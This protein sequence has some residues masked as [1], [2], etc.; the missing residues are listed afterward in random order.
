MLIKKLGAV[1]LTAIMTFIFISQD[2]K[3]SGQKTDSGAFS[4]NTREENYS[5]D[6]ND[7]NGRPRTVDPTRGIVVDDDSRCPGTDYQTIQAAVNAASP[8]DL[9]Q[10][11]PGVYQEQVAIS[12]RL[13]IVG[14]EFQNENQALVK[15]APAVPNS[16]SLFSGTPIAAIILVNQTNNVVLDNLTVD[17]ETNGIN[18]CNNSAIVGVFF[19]NASGSAENLAVRNIRAV[20]N[21]SCQRNFGIFAQSGGNGRSRVSVINSSIH[22][23]EKAG[24]VANENGTELT[25]IGNAVTGLGP[26]NANA[27]NGIQ[28][29]FGAKGYIAENSVI[30]HISTRCTNLQN[31][32]NAAGGSIIVVEVNDAKVLLNN[33]GKSQAGIF[34]LGDRAEISGNTVFDTD[35]LDAISVIGNRNEVRL[36][37]IFN[38]D[39]AGVFVSGNQNRVRNNTINEAQVG[40]LQDEAASNNNNLFDNRFFNTVKQNLNTDNTPTLGRGTAAAADSSAINISAVRP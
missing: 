7:N 28:V 19:R 14:V 1:F 31:C 15:P 30:N 2:M 9:I 8:G 37:R 25:A 21:G 13:T 3:V 35:V 17:G 33:T 16:T 36:N 39:R 34:V 18:G 27:Q 11:C 24:I 26:I 23:Y 5:R 32:G 38:S 29:G 10:V 12:K 22:D 40:V 4:Q 20:G 6:D